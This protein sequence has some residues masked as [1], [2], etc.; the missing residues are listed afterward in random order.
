MA[1]RE[2]KKVTKMFDVKFSLILEGK[3]CYAG[4]LLD[5]AKFQNPK[6]HQNCMICLKVTAI[7]VTKIV[8]FFYYFLRP[9]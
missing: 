7:L 1:V 4:L 8:F 9:C 6:G 5:P 3:G 2:G